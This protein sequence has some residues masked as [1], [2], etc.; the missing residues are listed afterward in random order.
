MNVYQA[1]KVRG[2]FDVMVEYIDLFLALPFTFIALSGWWKC[3][4]ENQL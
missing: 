3:N 2:V 4:H 1:E